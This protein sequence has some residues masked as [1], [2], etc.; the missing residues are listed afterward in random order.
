MK[1][2]YSIGLDIGTNSVGWAVI[3]DDYKVPAKKMKI[4]ENKKKKFIK[5][6]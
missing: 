6:N 2:P 1:K 3:T 4:F 5:K